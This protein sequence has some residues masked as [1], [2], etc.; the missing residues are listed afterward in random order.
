MQPLGDRSASGLDLPV[1]EAGQAVPAGRIDWRAS[2]GLVVVYSVQDVGVW[3]TVTRT[4]RFE[5]QDSGR[6]EDVEFTDAYVWMREQ[7]RARLGVTM[8]GSWPIWGWSRIRREYL[9]SSC[10]RSPGQVLLRLEIPRS[11][12]LISDF[13]SWHAVLNSWPLWP[14]DLDSGGFDEWDEAI[15]GELTALGASDRRAVHQWPHPARRLME[16]TWERIFE[17][18]GVRGARQA[19]VAELRAEWVRGAVKVGT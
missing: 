11:E 19:T 13:D 4:G 2:P 8:T 7:M 17:V 16:A 1:R 14:V 5:M 6:F 10:R 3:E 12:V 15:W 9:V 18:T